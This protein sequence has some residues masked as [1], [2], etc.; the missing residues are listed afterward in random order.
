MQEN[1]SHYGPVRQRP[2]QARSSPLSRPLRAHRPSFGQ[3]PCLR[4]KLQPLA[5]SYLSATSCFAI[6]IVLAARYLSVLVPFSLLRYRTF[7][8]KNAVG[9]L[10]WGG[11]R[12]GLSVAL[13]LSVPA[14][15]HGQF[16]V[17]ITYTVVLFSIL[18]QGLTIGKFVR[19]LMP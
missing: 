14:A 3:L 17:A 18:V 7:F 9:V 4:P 12:G 16:L 13:A 15:M 6:P 11:L 1:R 8:E 19:R 10:T 5:A 2:R